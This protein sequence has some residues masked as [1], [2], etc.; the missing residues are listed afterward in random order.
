MVI[1]FH[2]KFLLIMLIFPSVIIS[3]TAF[4]SEEYLDQ[5][6]ED[7]ILRGYDVWMLERENNDFTALYNIFSENCVNSQKFIDVNKTANLGTDWRGDNKS[8]ECPEL[9]LIVTNTCE[10]HLGFWKA[11]EN[12]GIQMEE[13]RY[14]YEQINPVFYR[15]LDNMTDPNILKKDPL[16]W[17]HK[18]EQLYN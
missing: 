3:I 18:Y 1:L 5:I 17:T 11:C 16:F 8:Y 9:A 15:T 12:F 10:I 4:H 6:D 13:Y 14:E 7:R 2:I